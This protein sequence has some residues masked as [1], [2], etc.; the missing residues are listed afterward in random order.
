MAAE[1]WPDQI[2]TPGTAIRIWYNHNMQWWIDVIDIQITETHVNTRLLVTCW[3]APTLNRLTADQALELTVELP[4]T[5]ADY[6]SNLWMWGRNSSSARE[7]IMQGIAD[8]ASFSRFPS[9]AQIV[10]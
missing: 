5:E 6:S 3:S 9:Q 8:L 2:E 1:A 4:K 7:I 10:G